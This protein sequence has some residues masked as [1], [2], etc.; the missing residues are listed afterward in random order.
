MRGIGMWQPWPTLMATGDKQ[1]ETRGW[2]T[3]HR[4]PLVMCS[5]KRI[6]FEAMEA[7][8]REPFLTALANEPGW[9]TQ[10][11]LA[12]VIVN[13]KDC[14]LITE[15]LRKKVLKERGANEIA[16]GN[17]EPGRYA[18][19]CPQVL[20]IPKPFPVR[21]RQGFFDVPD[22]LLS[23]ALEDVEKHP[24]WYN[25]PCGCKA[26]RGELTREFETWGK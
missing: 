1:N 20:R 19:Y 2:R 18:W 16:F 14:F 17:W 24:D 8:I 23:V 5:T 26:C 21:G 4:G 22:Q 10:L 15:E 11:G 6:P 3:D 7:A 13:L 12:L 25:G 9:K